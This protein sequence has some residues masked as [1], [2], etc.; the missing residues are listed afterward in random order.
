MPSLFTPKLQLWES[1]LRTF[2]A[3]RTAKNRLVNQNVNPYEEHT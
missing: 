3:E 1:I 2:F